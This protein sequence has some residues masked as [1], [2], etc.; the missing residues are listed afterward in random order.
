MLFSLYREPFSWQA[1][2]PPGVL[3]VISGFGPTAGAAL[4][5]HMDVDKVI[6]E[7]LFSLKITSFIILRIFYSSRELF[8]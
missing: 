5:S 6:I 2:L 8:A 1:G 3:N 4:C 7:E